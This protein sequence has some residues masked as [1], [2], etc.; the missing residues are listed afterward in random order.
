MGL[1]GTGQCVS[2]GKANSQHRAERG[3]F[4]LG[5]GEQERST[6]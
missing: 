6:S 2:C 4:R 5:V 1:L 3:D